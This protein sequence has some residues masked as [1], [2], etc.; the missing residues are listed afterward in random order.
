[1][2]ATDIQKFVAGMD[3]Q[4]LKVLAAGDRVNKPDRLRIGQPLAQTVFLYES[5]LTQVVLT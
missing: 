4:I 3:F 5:P 2:L 1:M